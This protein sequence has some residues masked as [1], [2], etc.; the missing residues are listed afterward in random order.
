MKA[1]RTSPASSA[2]R[3]A[4]GRRRGCRCCGRRGRRTPARRSGP[5]SA[6]RRSRRHRQAGRVHH[7]A[8][9]HEG[10]ARGCGRAPRRRARTPAPRRPA[11]SRPRVRCT[12]ADL[13]ARNAFAWSTSPAV[14]RL[15]DPSDTRRRAALDLVQQAGPRAVGEHGVGAGAQQEHPL[16]RGHCLVHRPGGGERSPIAPLRS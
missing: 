16:H 6:R 11:P 2:L 14:I 5:R 1:A 4:A 3:D 13:P 10:Q 9:L 12:V 15:A 7:V 8:A